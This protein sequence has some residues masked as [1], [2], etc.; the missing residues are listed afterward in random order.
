MTSLLEVS[1]LRASYA[2]LAVL[3]GVDLRVEAGEVVVLLGANGAGK[4]TMARAVCQM[5]GV[6]MNGEVRLRGVS[7]VGRRPETLVSDGIAQVPQG[8]GTL[9]ELSVEENLIVGGYTRYRR[10]EIQ[11]DIDHW[12][13]VF[14]RLRERRKQPAGKLSGGEQQM[15]AIARA[16]MCHPSLLILDEPSIGLAPLIAREVIQI[17]AE[18]NNELA[19]SM[20]LVE[21][22][23]GLALS[24]ADRA[25]VLEAGHITLSGPA[26]ELQND[27]GV[28]RA[29]LGV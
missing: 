1:N 18:L 20:L 17:L 15:L 21:Q 16:L 28:R 8:R 26:S 11:R 6:T 4:T 13:E 22:N 12:F 24:I 19:T 7:I 3:H 27:D 5:P 29:Y 23:A 25:Y 2:D 10:G 14:P 9:A